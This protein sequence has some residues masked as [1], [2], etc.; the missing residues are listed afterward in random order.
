LDSTIK[1]VRIFTSELTKLILGLIKRISYK[2]TGYF[3]DLVLDYL[4]EKEQLKPFYHRSPRLKNFK[5][6]LNEKEAVF[7]AGQRIKLV[8]AIKSQY[9]GIEISKSTERNIQALANSKSYTV[10]TGH[11]LNLFT[12]PLYFL[13]KIFSAINLSEQLKQEYPSYHFIP[14]YWMASEDHDFDEINYFNFNGEKIEWERE[15]EGAVGDLSTDGLKDMHNRIRS[16]FGDSEPARYLTNL[17]EKAYL[18]DRSL[19][20]ATR[21]IAN[22]LFSKFGLVIV[23]GNDATLKEQFIPYAEREFSEK[24][25]FQDVEETTS[26]LEGLGY[27]KQVHPREINLFFLNEGKRERI[28][29]RDGT[30]FVN[31]TQIEFSYDKIIDELNKHPIRFSPNALLR[32]LYQ[33][34]ILPNVCYIGGG[35]ELAYWLQLKDYFKNVNV[36]FP[37][38]LLRNSL[39]LI[40]KRQVEKLK[41]FDLDIESLFC[42]MHELQKTHTLKLSEIEIDFTPQRNHLKEQFKALYELAEQTDRSFIGAVAAQEKKQLNGLDKLEKRLL[43]AE[44]RRLVDEIDRL[45]L[46]HEQL[47]PHESLQE[48]TRNFSEFYIEYGENLLDNLK[49]AIEPLSDGFTI[50][51]I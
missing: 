3:S 21:F 6:Q 32:P 5:E 34:V 22:E 2:E 38:L 7:S 51:E 47:F 16:E 8:Q 13:Y 36:P 49:E 50:L 17:F 4:S 25:S 44:K 15:S 27:K 19:A 40:S 11:Q 45:S 9:K 35:G 37:I 18:Q 30:F 12:G 43:K 23:D 20:S 10:T 46:L 48:R 1:E 31:N 14:I 41:K 24:R 39:L 28:I 29:E 33:E 26:R 42:S